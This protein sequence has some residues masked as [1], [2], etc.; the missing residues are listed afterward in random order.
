MAGACSNPGKRDASYLLPPD[1]ADLMM[2]T[3]LQKVFA[4]RRAAILDSIGAGLL[5]LRAD[6]GFAG[7]R[8]EYRAAGHCW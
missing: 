3:E 4:M 6:Y 1:T 2:N 7:G 5:M 8:H